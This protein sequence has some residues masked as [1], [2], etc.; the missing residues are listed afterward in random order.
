MI[1]VLA[2]SSINLPAVYVPIRAE[3]RDAVFNKK[4]WMMG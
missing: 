2:L 4:K 3:N 1:V